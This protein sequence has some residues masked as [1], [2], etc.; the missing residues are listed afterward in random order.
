MDIKELPFVLQT[1]SCIVEGC[2]EK[3]VLG[4]G[5]TCDEHHVEGSTLI[6]E[7]E[8]GIPQG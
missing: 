5:V 6:A 8:A 7:F 1:T 2:G 4:A 3:I